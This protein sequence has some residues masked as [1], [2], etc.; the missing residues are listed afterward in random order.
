V[1]QWLWCIDDSLHTCEGINNDHIYLLRCKG[2]CFNH[3]L[4]NI[5]L[6]YQFFKKPCWTSK[7]H[8]K[9]MEKTM[10]TNLSFLVYPHGHQMQYK[11]F[12]TSKCQRKVYL[13]MPTIIIRNKQSPQHPTLTLLEI[14]HPSS[15]LVIWQPLAIQHN[16]LISNDIH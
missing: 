14:K 11:H 13:H 6:H 12:R 3:G 10:G 16:T 7:S 9:R 5:R 2:Q 1:R 4:R 15:Q 8:P